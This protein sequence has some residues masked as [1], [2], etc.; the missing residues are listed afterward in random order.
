MSDRINQLIENI[1]EKSLLL[2]ERIAS[3][4]STNQQLKLENQDLKQRISS[5]EER[6]VEL[7]EG[8]IDVNASIKAANEQNIVEPTENGISDVQIDE[9]VKEIEYCIGQLKK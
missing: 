5:K 3:K 2:Q 4:Q 8:I 6:I 9:L 7:E 1:R